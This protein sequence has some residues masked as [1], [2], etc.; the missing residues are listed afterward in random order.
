[1]YMQRF[2]PGFGFSG[3][4]Y[5]IQPMY[6]PLVNYNT[7]FPQLGANH[8]PP[9]SSEHQPRPLMQHLSGQWVPPSA[10]GGVGYGP[11]ETMLPPF[12]PGLISPHSNSPLYLNSVQYTCQQSGLPYL[13]PLDQIHQP[14]SQ[15]HQAQSD[16]TFGLARPR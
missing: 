7:E 3:G 12:S 2:D 10:P 6:A 8:R 15:S 9:I 4:P 13:H 16:N 14:F 11:A 1:R 5:T